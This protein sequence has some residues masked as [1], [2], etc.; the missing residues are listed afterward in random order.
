[1]DMEKMEGLAAVTDQVD[2]DV[3]PKTP[4][5]EAAEEAAAQAADPNVQAKA[6]GMLAFSIGGMLSILAPELKSVYTDEACLAWGHAVVPVAEK[7]GW[8]GPG[9]VPELGLLMASVPLALPTYLV[10]RKRIAEL[11]AARDQANSQA[12]DAKIV[13]E[14]SGQV[15]QGG[16]S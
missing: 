15:G 11:K 5:Q 2:A 12:E 16:T 10:I 13:R 1:M 6:W 7:Y 8:D 14:P 9:K 4:E 3:I